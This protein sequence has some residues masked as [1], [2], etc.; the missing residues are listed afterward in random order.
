[1]RK[2]VGTVLIAF[3]CTAIAFAQGQDN[4]PKLTPEQQK[5]MEAYMKAGTP[6]AEHQKLAAT[7]GSYALKVKSW[8][9]PGAAPIEDSAKATR[10][11]ALDGRVLMEEIHGTMMGGPYNG[12]GMTGFDNVTG[13]YWSTYTDS[14]STGVMVSQ[15]TCDANRACTFTGTW[16]DALKKAPVTMKMTSRWTSPT[17]EVWEMHGPA[18]DGK[19]FKMMEMTYTKQ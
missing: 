14:M 9:E 4:A 10:T 5:D 17:T 18:K 15:G 3:A 1:M 11:M 13:K 2:L 6:G 19:Q 16:N 7:A 8:M 12:H